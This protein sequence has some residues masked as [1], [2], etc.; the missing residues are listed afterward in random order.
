MEVLP[1]ANFQPDLVVYGLRFGEPVI[2][3]TS[4]LVSVVCFIA[5]Y[6]LGKVAKTNDALRLSRIFFLLMGISTLIGAV[7]GHLFLYRLPFVFKAPGWV[8]G[9]VA[10]SALEQ[11]SIV[12]AKPLLG[13]GWG[14][15][16]GW[17]NMVQLT[18]ALWFVTATLWFPG[19]EIHSAFGFLCIIV[20]LEVLLLLKTKQR[21][22]RYILQGILLLLFAVSFHI[23]K[24]SLGVWFSYFDFAHLLM[25]ASFWCFMRGAESHALDT[26]FAQ[27]GEGVKI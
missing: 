26:D 23:A 12:R 5:W 19:V 21:G 11:A 13:R 6:R 24:I 16:L 1:T 18:L 22:S 17:I 27:A 9:M 15:A 10:V 14:G 3:L 2:A 20:P 8:L 4:I 7:V 25:C